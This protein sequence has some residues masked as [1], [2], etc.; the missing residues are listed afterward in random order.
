LGI[1]RVPLPRHAATKPVAGLAILLH[2]GPVRVAALTAWLVGFLA[3]PICALAAPRVAVQPFAGT[4]T[5]PYRRQVARIVA[6]HGFKVI[7]SLPAVTGTSQYPG[8]AKDKRLSAL[9]VADVDDR[10]GR[11]VLSF[12]VWQGLD[13]SVIGRW[14]VSGAKKTI[15]ARLGREFWQRLGP[16]IRRAMAPPS[17]VLSPAP[18]MRINAGP[19][20]APPHRRKPAR[21]AGGGRRTAPVAVSL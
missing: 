10:G 19:D 3:A 4:D 21:P 8:L 7:T 11:V 14:E 16:A 5:E 12:L 15:G 20:R 2:D 13:G 17:D 18:P 6:R 1:D 9:V